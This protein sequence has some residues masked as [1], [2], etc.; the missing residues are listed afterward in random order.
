[1]SDFQIGLVAVGALV[2][3]CVLVYNRLQERAARRDAEGAFKTQHVD[4]LLDEQDPAARREPTLE[5][6]P[7]EPLAR[8]RL[9]GAGT[10]EDSL[11]DARLDYVIEFTPAQPVL[12]REIFEAW[13]AHERRFAPRAMLTGLTG[14][15]SWRRVA[16]RDRDRLSA[17][18][19]ALQLVNRGG[20]VSEADLLEFR[21]QVESLAAGL[22]AEIA[23]APEMRQALEA[24]REL[25][26]FCAEHDI[27]AVIHVVAPAGG[28]LQGSRIR[29]SAEAAGLRLET[30]G[31]FG[32]RDDE[33]RLLYT[34]ADRAGVSFSAA[35][36]RDTAV[37]ALTLAIDVPRAPGTQRTFESM[38]RLAGN[39]TAVLGAALVDDNDRKLDERALA[40]I[41]SQLDAV[42][43]SMD[44]RGIEPGGTLALRLFS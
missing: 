39:L 17:I 23:P 2:V 29:A 32:L 31:R 1:M 34:L 41:A 44:S 15:G 43:R 14:D 36:I 12:E 9:P 20:V 33:G 16:L 35:T 30:D 26:G 28:V 6:A 10:G 37:Q 13:A 4:I 22:G 5:A 25:D 24:A 3:L 42:R 19:T 38:A 40:A 18:R 27:Q 8:P 21:S 11:P 7:P